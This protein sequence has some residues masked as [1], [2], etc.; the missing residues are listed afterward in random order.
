MET[1]AA[2]ALSVQLFS[3]PVQLTSVLTAKL[4][5]ETTALDAMVRESIVPLMGKF[6]LLPS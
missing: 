3:V 1:V 2:P 4:A 6:V 5:L